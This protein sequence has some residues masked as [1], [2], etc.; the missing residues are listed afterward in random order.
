MKRFVAIV[1]CTLVA[2]AFLGFASGQ[3][4]TGGTQGTATVAKG[5]YG[6]APMLA[7]KVRKGELPAVEDRL[8]EEPMV[9]EPVEEIGQY[10]GT[11]RRSIPSLS[12]MGL[13]ARTGYECLVKWAPDGKTVIPGVARAY[14]VSSEASTYTFF[15]RKGMKWSD[16]EPFSVD[17][18]EFWYENVLMNKELSPA[19]PSWLVIKG[20]PVAF[21]RIDDQTFEMKFAGSYG[22]FIKQLAFNGIG[23]WTPK[24]YL[25]SYH[26]D[27]VGKA[28][29]DKLVKDAEFDNWI[30]LYGRKNDL[31]S[32][33]DLPSLKAWVVLNAP[34]DPT[35]FAERNAFYWKVDTA[36]NQLPYI[37]KMAVDIVES[38]E[39]T[40]ARAAA[41]DT[42]FEYQYLRFANWTMFKEGEKAGDYRVLNWRQGESGD[43][44]F[45][46]FTTTDMVMRELIHQYKFR[47]ALSL[48]INREEVNEL[49]YLGMAEPAWMQFIPQ[50]E[51]GDDM[52]TLKSRYKDLIT[53]YQY[54]PDQANKLLDEVGLTKRDSQGFRLRP[55]GKVLFL[56]IEA[57]DGGLVNLDGFELV[58]DH[59]G[60]VGIKASVR[61]V[62]GQLW[63]PRI[64]S[65]EY[66]IAGYLNTR[67]Q[68]QVY[69]RDWAPLRRHTYWAPQYGFWY[70]TGGKSGEEPIPELREAQILFDKITTTPDEGERERLSKELLLTHGKSL[71]SIPTVSTFP[72]PYI[73]KNNFRNVPNEGYMVWSLYSPGYTNPE[74]YFF[75][76]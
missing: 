61:P 6:E 59:W 64:Y 25:K 49:V 69:P 13:Q 62:S 46:N 5:K 56:T 55:D 52:N 47:L 33:P 35:I 53:R 22:L 39:I 44:V 41:G 32:N 38:D 51:W 50:E 31:R 19:V 45:P 21:K 74:Q 11:W 36:G 27:F 17:D 12:G 34:P 57:Y 73:V 76:K 75:K 29:L 63:W 42:D 1:L 72:A 66:V 67:V 58:K 60:K 48:S 14:E 37:D 4:D 54:D 70:D 7:E 18:L 40:N 28:E 9:I 24:H 15:L 8:P 65:S 71:W 16:G 43:V 2:G 3:K 23:M 10:G 20:E 26:P 30:Q 68:W